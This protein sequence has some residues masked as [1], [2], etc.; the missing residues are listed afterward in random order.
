VS[1]EDKQIDRHQ[2]VLIGIV[3]EEEKDR[4]KREKKIRRNKMARN[5]ISWKKESVYT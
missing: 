2:I 1:I 4:R 3:W 5:E